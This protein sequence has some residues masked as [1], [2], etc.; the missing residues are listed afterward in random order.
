MLA[1]VESLKAVMDMKTNEAADFRKRLA[2]SSQKAAQLPA[3][4]EK[5]SSLTAKCEDLESQL[6]RKSSYEQ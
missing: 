2:E 4:L 5:I 1:E 6:E 3:A